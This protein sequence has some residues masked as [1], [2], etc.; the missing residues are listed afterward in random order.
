[1]SPSVEW[2]DQQDTPHQAVGDGAQPGDR[3]K[4]KERAEI[5][6][7]SRETR[8]GQAV[9]ALNARLGGS[10]GAPVQGLRLQTL[11]DK[12]RLLACCRGSDLPSLDCSVSSWDW[13]LSSGKGKAICNSDPRQMGGLCWG[14]WGRWTQVESA[15]SFLMAIPTPD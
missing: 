5:S 10:N 7:K 8:R 15:A 14:M 6:Y 1:M 9:K 2:D 12:A 11:W 3:G 13:S 4:R